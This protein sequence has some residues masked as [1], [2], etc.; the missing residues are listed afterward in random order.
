MLAA[1]P[2]TVVVSEASPVDSVLRW[3]A[4]NL[5]DALREEWLRWTLSALG[6]RRSGAER[7]F[8]VKF[9]TWSVLD[10][11]TVERAFPGVPWVF[12]YRDPAEVLASQFRRRSAHMVPGVLEPELFGFDAETAATVPPEEYCARILARIYEAAL[13]RAE[14]DSALLVHYRE[15]PEAVHS[16]IA[17][18]FGLEC[19]ESDRELLQRRALVDAKNP[20]VPFDADAGNRGAAGEALRSAAETFVGPYYERLEALRAGPRQALRRRGRR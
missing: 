12:L 9:D 16:L 13:R 14:G 15:L 10:L 6:Q 18:F 1:L 19:G 7:H 4:E 2:E 8:V 11:A 3:K 20:Y 17:P 5:S